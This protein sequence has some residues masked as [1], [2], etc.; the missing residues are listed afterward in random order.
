[1]LVR[2]VAKNPCYVENGREYHG[3]HKGIYL[4]PCD[5]AEQD[6][7]DVFHKLFEVARFQKLHYACIPERAKPLEKQKP[8]VEPGEQVRVLDL[9]CGTGIWAIEMA[10]IYPNAYFLGI[11]LAAIQPQNRPINC[12]FHAPCD[13]EGLWALGEDS[14]DLINLRMG[15]GSVSS[16]PDLYRRVIAHLRPGGSFEQ[17]EI[18]FEPRCEPGDPPPQLMKRWYSELKEATET[19]RRPIAYQKNTPDMLKAAGFVEIVHQIVGLPMN[20]WPEVEHENKVGRWY[21][22]ALSESLETLSLAPFSRC[23]G[24]SVEDIRKYAAEVKS[25]VFNKQI[26]SFNLIHI[27]TARKPYPHERLAMVYL[28]LN[29]FFFA[30]L[31]S[32]LADR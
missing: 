18:D 12:D 2:P 9:G 20:R 30:N 24:M 22:L 1:M 16:W 27:F 8:L 28:F 10:K 19:V 3:Y 21:N 15:C 4:Y 31:I 14:W 17:I 6:R 11:D 7:L 25:E 32:K 13:F 29:L 26:R 23:K 5:E